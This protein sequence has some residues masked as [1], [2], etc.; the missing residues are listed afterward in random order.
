MDMEISFPGGKRVEAK[1]D[2]FIVKTDQPITNGGSGSAP[3]P[4]DL[5]LASIGTCTG[6]Y[7]LS[8]CLKNNI[9]TENIQLTAHFRRN[10][11]THLVENVQIDIH[12]PKNFPEKYKNAVVKA[13]DVCSVKKHL[14]NPPTIEITLISS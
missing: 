13:A 6:Y 4:L 9:P 5:F 11:E 10:P 14:E 8:F 1:Y 3:S 7:V 2:G 12:V